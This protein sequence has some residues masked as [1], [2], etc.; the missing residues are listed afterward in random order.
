MNHRVKT[1]W[2]RLVYRSAGILACVALTGCGT[3]GDAPGDD[4][5]Q[6]YGGVEARDMGQTG[7][8]GDGE[9]GT[10]NG[11]QGAESGAQTQGTESGAQ[12]Q[13]AG[14]GV[15]TQGTE[16]GAQ[17]QG[18]GS[19]VQTQGTEAGSGDQSQGIGPGQED[20][21]PRGNKIENQSFQV[22]LRPLGQVT[23]ASYKPDTS[24][25]PLADVVFL[26]EK[27]GEIL[28]QLPGTGEGNIGYELFAQVDAVSFVDYNN[29]GYDDIIIILQYYFGAGPQAGQPHS[30]LRYY[31]GSAQGSF[32]YEAQ[33]SD[34]A[35]M[36]LTELTV[37]TAKD[38]IMVKS[39]DTAEDGGQAT[40]ND[41]ELWQ[42]AYLTYLE[43][44]S[45]EDEQQGYT[46]IGMSSDG[47]PQ[48]VEVGADEAT[49]CRI[50]FY[51]GGKAQVFQ[52][53]RLYFSYI[54]SGNLLCNS[55]GNMDYYYDLVYKYSNGEIERIAEGWYG[56]EDNSQVEYDEN[57]DPIYLYKWNGVEVDKEQYGQEL[58]KVYDV[59]QAV[60][61][62]YDNLYSLQEVKE[63]VKGYR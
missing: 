38:F 14:S 57:G 23:F 55:E 1:Y 32:L 27:E 61:Y 47:I 56:A 58:G 21:Y 3:V 40:E 44:E 15:Q 2:G 26:I 39:S 25:N 8:Q 10:G 49:G 63:A 37:K 54:P 5:S 33:M 45:H 19:G 31:T 42:Q 53:N 6:Y 22:E 7:T 43:T 48:L 41:L 36:A 29:D 28:L 34:D 46:L 24:E 59:F 62:S 50:V 9:P 20:G 16:S 51:S 17:I 4:T 35:M 30:V 13:G 12:I 52:L 18:A 11:F 60:S